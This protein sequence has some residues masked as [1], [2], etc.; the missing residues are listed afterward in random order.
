MGAVTCVMIGLFLRRMEI[1]KLTPELMMAGHYSSECIVNI[2]AVR[3]IQGA[4]GLFLDN[5]VKSTKLHLEKK[6]GEAYGNAKAMGLAQGIQQYGLPPVLWTFIGLL[7]AGEARRLAQTHREGNGGNIKD[8][9][10]YGSWTQEESR[11]PN[12]VMQDI[13]ASIVPTIMQYSAFVSGTIYAANILKGIGESLGRAVWLAPDSARA[14]TAAH[15]IF[16]IIDR[17][18]AIDAE[19]KEIGGENVGD[20]EPVSN[21]LWF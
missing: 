1:D 5:Y 11:N 18:P 19:K 2:R 13:F 21:C 3:T 9:I 17:V 6:L 20:D 10:L 16:N 14:F 4:E 12:K 15:D 8:G 7:M